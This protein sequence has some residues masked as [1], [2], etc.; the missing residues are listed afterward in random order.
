MQN[1]HS[2]T[3]RLLGWMYASVLVAIVCFASLSVRNWDTRQS[4]I[5]PAFL[6]LFLSGGFLLARYFHQQSFIFHLLYRFGKLQT[7]GGSLRDRCLMNFFIF[8]VLGIT[9]LL[10]ARLDL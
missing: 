3:G 1:R 6:L 2:F 9:L 5:F 4:E 10:A 7:S 8:S